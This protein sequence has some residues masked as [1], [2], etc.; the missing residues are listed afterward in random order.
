ME[1][2]AALDVGE[3]VGGFDGR[4]DCVWESLGLSGSRCRG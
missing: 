2:W 1:L 3:A 4:W